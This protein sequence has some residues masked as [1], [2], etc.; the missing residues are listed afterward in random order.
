MAGV[1]LVPALKSMLWW[2]QY[3]WYWLIMALAESTPLGVTR[4]SAFTL[5]E[6]RVMS[7]D[8]SLMPYCWRKGRAGEAPVEVPAAL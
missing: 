2:P 3:A 5:R 1:P 7:F 4:Q 8:P 6:L